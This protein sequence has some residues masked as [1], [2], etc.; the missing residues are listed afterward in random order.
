MYWPSPWDVATRGILT[1]G[2]YSFLLFGSQNFGIQHAGWVG[3]ERDGMCCPHT[4]QW[5]TV[6]VTGAEGQ[7]R[8]GQSITEMLQ[9]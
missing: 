1:S 4:P 5:V 7:V 9:A 6:G 2:F 3:S 8:N